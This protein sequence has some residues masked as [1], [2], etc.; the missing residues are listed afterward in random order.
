[1]AEKICVIKCA[2]RIDDYRVLNSLG[3][4]KVRTNSVKAAF[5]SLMYYPGGQVQQAVENT[6]KNGPAW[7]WE[8]IKEPL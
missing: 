7:I 3:E 1:M 6:D 4:F 2:K 8:D 5:N